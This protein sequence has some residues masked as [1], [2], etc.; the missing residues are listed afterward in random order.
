MR[1]RLLRGKEPLFAGD[2]MISTGSTGGELF[3]G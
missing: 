3:E 1:K 2:K